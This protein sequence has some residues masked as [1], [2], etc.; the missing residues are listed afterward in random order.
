MQTWLG[1]KTEPT[2]NPDGLYIDHKLTIPNATVED[3]CKA[4]GRKGLYRNNREKF[5]DGPDII[6]TGSIIDNLPK[7]TRLI[8]ING[9]PELIAEER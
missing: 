7:V 6:I 2:I 3:F 5:S 8:Y 1:C 4:D 9:T